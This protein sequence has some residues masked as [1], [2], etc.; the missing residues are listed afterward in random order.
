MFSC[1]NFVNQLYEGP[2]HSFKETE[3]SEVSEHSAVFSMQGRRPGNE[4]RTVIKKVEMVEEMRDLGDDVHIWAVMDG[5]GGDF[6]AD[7]TAKH[8]IPSLEKN[9]QKLKILTSKLIKT[10]NLKIYEKHFKAA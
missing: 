6:C 3:W 9:V 10:E 5:H 4:D 2:S 1:F 8:L 7:Y